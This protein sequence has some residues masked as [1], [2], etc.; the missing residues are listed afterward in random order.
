MK[1]IVTGGGGFIASHVVDA[2]LHDGHRVAVIDQKFSK[3]VNPKAKFYKA[4]ICDRTAVEKIFKREKPEIVNHHA[5]IAAVAKS[6]RDPMP[7]LRTNVLGTVNVLTAFGAFGAG[8][9]KKFIFASTGGAMYGD[10]PKPVPE[11]VA[12]NPLSPYGLSKLLA[13]DAVVFYA[14]Y[15]GFTYVIFRYANVFGPRQSSLGEAGVVPIFSSLMR[16]GKRPIIFG[17]GTKSRDY[18]FVGDIAQAN[19]RALR[20]GKNITM[21]IGLGT[22]ISDQMIFDAIARELEFKKKPIY[23]PFR[24][25]E[26][27]EIS[28][29]AKRARKIL[30]WKP[31]VNLKDGLRQTLTR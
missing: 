11:T 2:Y 16:A 12:A 8:K 19:Q 25:G 21:N 17:D 1:I 27:Y 29:D 3:N 20:K 24:K 9:H 23:A 5:A 15:Y 7:T 30:G 18:V 4:D 10:H 6:L 13:E 31:R 22:K 14:N 28:L 26:I